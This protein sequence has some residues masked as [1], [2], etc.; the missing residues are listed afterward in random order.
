MGN[1]VA[2]LDLT[3]IP[4]GRTRSRFMVFEEDNAD[5]EER[6]PRPGKVVRQEYPVQHEDPNDVDFQRGLYFAVCAQGGAAPRRR[7]LVDIAPIYGGG[8]I[9]YTYTAT[10][11]QLRLDTDRG[12]VRV[13]L[14]TSDTMRI[15]GKGVGVR[16]YVK[17]PFMSMTSAQRLPSGVVEYNLRSVYAGG[18]V[19]FF[20]P[21]KGEITLDSKFD[22]A[23]NG[24]EYIH[25]EFLPDENGEFEVAAY[26]MSPDEWGYIEY[27]DIDVCVADAEGEFKS[28]LEKLSGVDA[29]WQG[30][31]ELSAYAMWIS[32]QAKSSTPVMPTLLSDMIYADMM[33]EGQARA[34]EQPLYSMAFAD[35]GEA[36][37]LIGNNLPHMQNGMLPAEISDS[38]P[39]FRAFPPTFGVAALHL[40]KTAGGKLSASAAETLYAQ[41]AEHYGWWIGSHS[42]AA[43]HLSYNTRDEY[44]FSASSYSVLPFPLETPDLYA[45]MILYAEAL[46]ELSALVGDGKRDEWAAASGRL[47]DTL[48][49]L[50]DGDGGRFVCRGAISGRRYESDSLLAYLPV[51]LGKRLPP[52]ILDALAGRLGDEDAFLSPYGFRSESGKSRSFNAAAEGRGAVDAAL[53][54]PVIG[55]LF[56]AGATELAVKAAERLLT[57]M[58]KF[59]ARDCLASEGAQPVRRP[60]DEINPIGG[61]AMIFLANKLHT[62]GKGL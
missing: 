6:R 32:Y 45:Y 31:K 30:L 25:A 61:A 4:F 54:M 37:R 50:W 35:A 34:Y 5:R 29:R 53:Q 62:C 15:A 19:F 17:L 36:A 59:G 44:G 51:M 39:N 8:P 2:K 16:L 49:T 13:V 7:G 38:R 28:F 41:L 24:P 1:S 47:L 56:D 27:Q 11:S 58:E 60:A 23:L 40:L 57:A 22:P 48:L 26:S 52:D 14:D 43:D 21:L 3:K 9:P 42:L 55:G 12:A 46:A 18:G 20:K 10:P 33:R